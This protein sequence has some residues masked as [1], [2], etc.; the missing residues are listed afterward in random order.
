M[1]LALVPC[2]WV[3]A[4]VVRV[5]PRPNSSTVVLSF[6]GCVAFAARGVMSIY[7]CLVA[8]ITQRSRSCSLC[9][10]TVVL[11]VSTAMVIPKK[12]KKKERRAKRAGDVTISN[13]HDD[14]MVTSRREGL[15]HVSA[16]KK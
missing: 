15:A 16:P 4:K 8:E 6:L 14:G 10:C 3:E 9:V 2:A 1:Y 12:K 7:V 11:N 13:R 5:P